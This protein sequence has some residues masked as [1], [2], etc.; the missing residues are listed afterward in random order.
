[1]MANKRKR[2]KSGEKERGQGIYALT[3]EEDW[4]EKGEGN[5]SSKGS[6][7]PKP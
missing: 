4:G 3:Q 6:L 7:L 2:D 1:M 5:T